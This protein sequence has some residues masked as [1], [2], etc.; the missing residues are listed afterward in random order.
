M[1]GIGLDA[2]PRLAPHMRLR[3]DQARGSWTI[4][5]PERSFLLDE[6]AHAIVS[7]CDGTASLRGIADALCAAYPGASRDV[8]ETDILDLVQNFLDKGVMTL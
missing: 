5:A 8:I 6:T 2:L 3:M 7:R 4:Q 1:T